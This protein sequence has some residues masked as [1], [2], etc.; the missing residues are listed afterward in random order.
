MLD[1]W[2]IHLVKPVLKKTAGSLNKLGLSANQITG[3]GFFIGM[4]AVPALWKQY[5]LLALGFIVL[6]RI[7]DGLDGELAR[8]RGTSD[9]GGYL[10]I[11]L[12]FI[13]YSAVIWGFALANPEV[14]ALASATLIFSFIGTG[15]SFLAFAIIAAKLNIEQLNCSRKSFYYLGGLTEGTET[16]VVLILF[17][18]FPESFP[19]LAYIFSGMCWITVVFRVIAGYATIKQVETTK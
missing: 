18:V 1:K 17:C 11:T 7:F 13:F 9:A 4:M 6:N 2:S 15:S 10:D 14:N 5:Y 8:L 19:L 16:I 3:I 12:D